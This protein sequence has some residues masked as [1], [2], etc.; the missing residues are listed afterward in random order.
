ME[1]DR[2]R[3]AEQCARQRH[4]ARVAQ[5]EGHKIGAWESL[6]PLMREALIQRELALDDLDLADRNRVD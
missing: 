4:E 6:S 3:R 1:T 2:Q 5:L